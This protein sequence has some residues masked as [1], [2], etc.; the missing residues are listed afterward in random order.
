[1]KGAVSSS[2]LLCFLLLLLDY[3]VSLPLCID[4]RAPFTLNSTTNSFCP[5]NGS[6]CCNSTEDA[7]IQK[8]FQA[9]NISDS[10]CASLLK[11]IICARC[12][13][14]SAQLFT[15]ESSTRTVPVLCNSAIPTNSTQSK[16]VVAENFCSQVWDTCYN[17]S[18]TNSPFAPSLQG[19][20]RSPF[21]NEAAKLT[22][23]WQSKID[24]CNAFGGAS[25]NESVCYAGELVKLNKTLT[26]II[27]PHGLCLEKIGNGS[28]L[29]MVAHPDGSNRAFFSNQKG[30]VWLATLPDQGSG[31]AMEFDE[32]S[33]FVDLTDQVHFDPAFGMMGM[34]FHPDFAKNGRFFASFNCDKSE[35]AGC[36]GRCSCN[37][38]VNC[39]PSK[40][41][42]DSGKQPCQYQT[43]IAEYTANGTASQPSSAES[44]KP[45][46]VR[47]IFTM[48][49]PF[50]GNHGG[51]ILF[52]PDDGYLYFMMGDGGGTG[53]PFNFSQNKKSLLGKIMRLDVDNIP[54]AADIAKLDFWG[55]Y[56]IPKDN[57]YSEDKDLQPEIWALGLRNPWRCSFDSERA[58]YFVCADTGQDLY[59]EVDLITKGGNYGWSVYEGPLL[60][61]INGLTRSNNTLSTSNPIFP[62]LGYNHSEVNKKEGSASIIGGYFYRST[63]DPCMFGRYLYGD[64]YAGAIWAGDEDPE[65]SGNFTTSKIPFSCSNDSPIKCDS[66][67]GSSLPSL[68]Y[69][70]S[71]GEDNN[72][73]IYILASTGVYRVVRAT[74]CNY[75]CSKENA[76]AAANP[77]PS[78][79]SSHASRWSNFC[80]NLM[81]HFSFF[82]LLLLTF[83]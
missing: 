34:A 41:V 10:G 6:T 57:P 75:V 3:S 7:Q 27:P 55:N 53:D 56:S 64:L 40:I 50:T 14:F 8:Q 24:F 81:L 62:V 13:P 58:S 1:M 61:Y 45:T 5:Y 20:A 43:V 67:P 66:V 76:T 77:S 16:T 11:S 60:F 49:L 46:E 30:K 71:F 4:S 29:N 32:S 79:V 70:Y 73:D 12:D 68:G 80:H 23:Q 78:P 47:R 18:I 48:G 25:T 21:N 42:T 59:E 37:S 39:D 33:P 83:L 17:V 63:T 2:F 9:M 36:T 51:Q 26:P 35:W 15:V 82:L 54:S 22:E 38:D 28:Y 44:A 52:G 19:E 72:K 74:R 69:I 31:G 65:N